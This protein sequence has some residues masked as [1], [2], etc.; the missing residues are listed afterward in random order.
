M[1]ENFLF[2]IIGEKI[3]EFSLKGTNRVEIF[4][5]YLIRF[6]FASTNHTHIESCKKKF[7]SSTSQPHKMF[8]DVIKEI[9]FPTINES[10]F[11]FLP[12][13]CEMKNCLTVVAILFSIRTDSCCRSSSFS[14]FL[15]LKDE[16]DTHLASGILDSKGVRKGWGGQIIISLYDEWLS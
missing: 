11:F 10:T 4:G 3:K 1:R 15:I 2:F 7:S 16:N 8:K 13:A 9:T 14:H 6:F 5:K 12:S